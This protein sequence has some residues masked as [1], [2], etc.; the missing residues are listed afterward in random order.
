MLTGGSV[1][2]PVPPHNLDAE[3]SVL[4]AILIDNTMF[5]AAAAAVD[6]RA[7]YRDAHRRILEHMAALNEKSQPIDFV[8]LCESLTR[9]GELEEVGGPVYLSTLIDGVPRASNA[10]HYANIV[11]DKAIER[12]T[13]ADLRAIVNLVQDDGITPAVVESLTRALDRAQPRRSRDSRDLSGRAEETCRTRAEVKMLLAPYLAEG[14]ILS[15][16]T[17]ELGKT[18]LVLDMLRH[19]RRGTGWCD[20]A[21][22]VQPFRVLYGTEQVQASFAKQLQDA[23]FDHDDGVIVTYL[24]AWKGKPWSAIAPRLCPTRPRPQ[25]AGAG[26]RHRLAVVWL[27]GRRGEQLRRRRARRPVAALHRAGRDR[28]PCATRA[29]E[30]RQRRGRRPRQQRYRGRR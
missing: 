19:G 12:V 6:S 13:Q 20:F 9:S 25:R 2:D 14:C 16:L 5:T 28:H 22:P 30:R 10:A 8:T 15:A 3:K 7:F 17:I 4:G 21:A 24:A 18:S 27:Q 11:A 29:Q 26:G 23:G 1:A